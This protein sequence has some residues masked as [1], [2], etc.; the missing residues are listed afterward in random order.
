VLSNGRMLSYSMAT[1]KLDEGYPVLM[2]AQN[3]PGF[4]RLRNARVAIYGYKDLGWF[5][6]SRGDRVIFDYKNQKIINP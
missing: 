1:N 4:E 2:S 3:W 5:F 6:D